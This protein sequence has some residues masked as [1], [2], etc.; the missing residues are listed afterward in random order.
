[1]WTHGVN[2]APIEKARAKTRFALVPAIARLVV[3]LHRRHRP[4][5]EG[6]VGAF[7]GVP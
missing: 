5:R 1:M 7:H 6:G 2:A 3:I 4:V